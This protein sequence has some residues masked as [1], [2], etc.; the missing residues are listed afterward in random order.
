MTTS[1]NFILRKSTTVTNSTNK[2]CW[3]GNSHQPS[4]KPILTK[5]RHILRKLWRRPTYTSRIQ[6]ATP[7]NATSKNQL[8]KWPTMAMNYENGS[9]ILQ[10]QAAAPTMSS[11]QT[12]KPPTKLHLWK[13][14]S[15]SWQQSLPRWQTRAT[16]ARTSI[17]TQA[18]TIATA[19][20]LGIRNHTTWADIATFMAT[21]S[22]VPTTPVWT[23]VGK[24]DSH[25]DEAT[26]TNT[27]GGDTFWPSAKHVAMN[28]QNHAIWK[29][30]SAPTNWQ[31]PGTA[32]HTEDDTNSAAFNKI[33]QRLSSNFYYCLSLPACQVEE[34]KSTGTPSSQLTSRHLGT[35]P[36]TRKKAHHP[37]WQYIIDVNDKELKEGISQG[38][39]P[40]TV[41]NSAATSDVGTI[42]DPF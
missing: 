3:H 25:K 35:T 18:V 39:I 13:H 14:R 20:A 6:A 26:W 9:S 17:P 12:H 11:L 1:Y 8:T 23:A 2:T 30:K 41:A 36:R 27:P 34:H 32:L 15:R 42:N 21:T 40:T 37:K 31:G 19:D 4:S 33:K 5:P 22:L 16:A 24:K 38:L 29:G 10:V 7:R 28:Q